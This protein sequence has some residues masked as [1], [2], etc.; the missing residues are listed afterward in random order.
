M[1][2]GKD[3][4]YNRSAILVVRDQFRRAL[5]APYLDILPR[6]E[7]TE[8]STNRR[9]L[10]K[11]HDRLHTLAYRHLGAARHWWAIAE[12]N[13]MIDPFEDFKPED[14]ITIP[15]PGTFQFEVLDFEF[16]ETAEGDQEQ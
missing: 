1:S 14:S 4:R 8:K 16:S 7:D 15:S 10:L 2:V 9:R 12:F 6:Y 11:D 5:R 3:S 13:Q